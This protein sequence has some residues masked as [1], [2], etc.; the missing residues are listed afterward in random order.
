MNRAA[1]SGGAMRV[2][3][4]ILMMVSVLP[5]AGCIPERLEPLTADPTPEAYVG[6]ARGRATLLP[7]GQLVLDG[8]SM[9]CAGRPTVLDPDLDDYAASYPRFIIINPTLM[10][11]VTTPVKLWIYAHECGHQRQGL[12]EV[13]A[14]CYGVQQG[15]REGWLTAD[16]LEKVCEFIHPGRRDSAHFSGNARC[17]LMRA[18]Y[19]AE[20]LRRQ[21]APSVQP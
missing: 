6:R 10:A 21:P 9:T 14:D 11:K 16:G 19:P 7:A 13:K 15:R 3:R 20:L 18:C 2:R 8:R 1:A 12:D 4:S 17:E 5:F